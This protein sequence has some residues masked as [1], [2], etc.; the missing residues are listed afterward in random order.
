MHIQAVLRPA[1]GTVAV[2]GSPGRRA[3]ESHPRRGS[4][5]WS[6]EAGRQAGRRFRGP[7]G[8]AHL[9]AVLR[10]GEVDEVIVVHL[11]GV[12]DVA[13]LLLAQVLG[14]DAVGPQ[15]LL[16]GHAEGLADGL[17]DQLGLWEGRPSG[18]R[19]GAQAL[20]DPG[21]LGRRG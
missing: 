14:V 3:P 21:G 19:L 12:D 17:G 8:V 4:S 13:V 2:P 1:V 7:W 16:V 18:S 9:L 6:A 11:L 15:E 10:V 20:G 5:A